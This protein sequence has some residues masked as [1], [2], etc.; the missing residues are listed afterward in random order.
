MT[1]DPTKYIELPDESDQ[2]ETLDW[3]GFYGED[4]LPPKP[5]I[6]AGNWT[7]QQLAAMSVE[8]LFGPE[9]MA[10]LDTAVSRATTSP[11]FVSGP[12]KSKIASS[13]NTSPTD[14]N[15]PEEPPPPPATKRLNIAHALTTQPP[16]RDFVLPCLRAGTV[17]GLISPGG[18]GK[19]MLAMQ[20]ALMLASGADTVQGLM[21]QTGWGNLRFGPALYASF[22]DGEDDAAAR[23]HTIW[24][25]LGA[26]AD[27]NAL[28]AATQNLA[29][30]TLT[31]VRPPDLLDY[32]WGK[33]LDDACFGRRLVVIDTLRTSH[34]A[35]ENDSAAMSR[36]LAT[37]QGAAIR[38]GCA[39]LFLHHT[40]KAATL[41][42]QGATQQAARGSS[43]I[44]DN[45]RGQ[46][47]LMGLSEADIRERPGRVYDKTAPG[48]LANLALSENEPDGSPRRLRYAR[49]GVSKSNYSAPWPEIW[50]RRDD[51][52]VLS[53]AA[54][55]EAGSLHSGNATPSGSDKKASSGNK[56]F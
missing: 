45:A 5:P 18:A 21:R 20:L 9:S 42:G 52:G 43:V 16:P 38:N 3:E 35:D 17:G 19:S 26:A 25:S 54:I 51:R 30:D 14:P 44:T 11:T 12:P 6:K 49:F 53:C 31:G 56:V 50:L 36:L 27:S 2:D 32:E 29:V 4:A 10:G 39:I 48:D 13:A 41:G 24:T 46:F 55:A 37:M 23:L 33:W 1:I 28:A 47:Y 7:P 34:L 8:D 40:S 22:E 15:Q